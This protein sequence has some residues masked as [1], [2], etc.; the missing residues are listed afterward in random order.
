MKVNMKENMKVK[1][2]LT[3]QEMAG[4]DNGRQIF[5]IIDVLRATSTITAALA[6]GAQKVIPQNSIEG[7]L[8]AAREYPDALLCGERKGVR[9][10]G[11]HLG[12]SPLEFKPETVGGKVLICTTT[13][14]TNAIFAAKGGHPIYLG[15]LNNA[16]A[17]AEAAFAVSQDLTILCAGTRG[18]PSVDDMLA[19]GSMVYRLQQFYPNACYDPVS[20]QVKQLYEKE[21]HDLNRALIASSHGQFLAKLSMTE[22][23]AYCAKENIIDRVPVYENGEI[24][25]S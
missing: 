16:W 4:R 8:T 17:C 3:W 15:C 24:C 25:F 21:R 22:D 5:I 19:A 18:N 1:T 14:G 12:N 23:I 11:F 20:I 9:I 13:N 2:I 10:A 7:A 6:A